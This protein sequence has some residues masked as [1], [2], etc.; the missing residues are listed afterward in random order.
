MSKPMMRF[1]IGNRYVKG[2]LWLSLEKIFRVAL[3]F[4]VS[5]FLIRYLS[6]AEFGVWSYAQG[7]VILFSTLTSLGLESIAVRELVTAEY[8]KEKVLGSALLLSVMGAILLFVLSVSMAWI[9]GDR[10][11]IFWM[12]V[13]LAIS[14]VFSVFSV[15]NFHF[16]AK[17][18][19][20]YSAWSQ[21][22]QFLVD[23]VGKLSVVVLG[24]SVLWLGVV[25]IIEFIVLALSLCVFYRAV[26]ESLRAW[27]FDR[28]LCWYLFKQS[29]PMAIS[30]IM[31]S[32]YMRIDQVMLQQFLGANAVGYYS[33][34]A[35]VVQIMYMLPM[36]MQTLMLPLLVSSYKQDPR[37]FER[38]WMLYCSTM[39]YIGLLFAIIFHFFS[40]W[41]LVLLFGIKY[42][43][44]IPVLK[45]LCFLIPSTFFGVASSVWFVV[46]YSQAHKLYPEIVA[47]I[48]NIL[49][50][51]WLIPH[52]GVVGAAYA[53]L[54]SSCLY[55][56]LGR[57]L[58]PVTR[59]IMRLSL[60]ALFLWPVWQRYWGKS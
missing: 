34:C 52:Y 50:N 21:M 13:L 7:F 42:M 46:T 14:N 30:G 3:S 51:M 35:R 39:F 58:T 24:L 38:R 20:R 1:L 29:V 10:G 12:V 37:C 32:I 31:I 17:V 33:V 55:F 16:Q 18:L 4:I 59:N 19:S 5:I 27:S 26:G 36:L 6:P 41:I 15:I 43:P 22:A 8:P 48:A 49:L 28:S 56:T 23:A 60:G 11:A 2:G 57:M 45:I 9:L 47:A 40:G 54:L 44:A 53:S 25:M